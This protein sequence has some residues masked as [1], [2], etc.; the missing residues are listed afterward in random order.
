MRI[1]C[2]FTPLFVSLAGLMLAGCAT[3]RPPRQVSG[4]AR[5]PMP[6]T[7]EET[8]H[9]PAPVRPAPV[10]VVRPAPVVIAEPLPPPVLTPTA[11]ATPRA[12][13]PHTVRRGE[14]LSGIA[15]QHRMTWRELADYNRIADP[16]AIRVGQTILIP[17]A[18]GAAAAAPAPAVTPRTAAAPVAGDGH[19]IVQPGDNL[20]VIARR[21]N[22]TISA[23]RQVN[24]LTSD[25]IRV[26]QRLTLPQGSAA[27]STPAVAA[28]A[29]ATPATP[30]A[31]PTP[32][33]VA[34][35]ETP[36][37]AT[38]APAAPEAPA[39]PADDRAFTIVVEEGDTLESISASYVVSVEALRRENNLAPN[40]Q[41]RPGDRLRIP[42]TSW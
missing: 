31:V 37:T 38:P 25:T 22:T 19:Y 27:P 30:R 6:P 18:P 41:V 1:N 36:A 11:P 5:R 33:P 14:T 17:P 15:L 16:N 9:E 40:A 10:E 21:H 35:P 29:P 23:L 28:P 12:G 26:G 24:N 13:T 42:P 39:P 3:Q 2:K 34:T 8:Y 4:P 32:R 20:T 7:F